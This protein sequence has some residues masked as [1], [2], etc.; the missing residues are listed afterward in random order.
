M[1]KEL[2]I[3][4]V[5][6]RDQD[7]AAAGL[8]PPDE[9][10]RRK[11]ALI[12]LSTA[13]LRAELKAA[14]ARLEAAARELESA[15]IVEAE[16][17][18]KSP[19]PGIV[20]ARYF[21]EGER[22]KRDDKILT[23]IDTESLYAVF[24]VREADARRLEK[25]M[26]ALVSLD[27]LETSY[28]GTVDLVAPQGDSQSFTFPVRVL[29]PREALA[30]SRRPEDGPDPLRPG[31]FVR[32]SVRLGPSRRGAFVPESALMNRQNNEAL[33]FTINGATLGE[34]RITIGEVLGTER[35]VLSG[36][37]PGEVV[38]I[39]PDSGLKEGLYVSV[40]E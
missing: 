36:L 2:E 5:G 4:R 21:E 29:L 14:E 3:R 12:R 22:V 27:G 10:A 11:W 30:P 18:L 24:S 23:L 32:V 20:G 7:L 39:R 17:T 34:R 25:G 6:M 31:M 40:V 1:E 8:S 16:L 26:N 28:R 37:E 19:A 9:E 38:V 13:T 15:R 35:E 33:V